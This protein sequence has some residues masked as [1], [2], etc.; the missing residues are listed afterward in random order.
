MGHNTDVDTT[1]FRQ[2]IWNYIHCMF[3]IRHDDYDYKEVNQMLERS[4]KSYVKTVTCYPERTT[5]K[6]Y[7]SFMRGLK[8]SEKVCTILKGAIL[9]RFLVKKLK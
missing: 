4:L 6:D 2:A 8:H 9:S 7:N 5:K 1:A 3:G